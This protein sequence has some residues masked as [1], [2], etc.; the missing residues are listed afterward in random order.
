M[1]VYVRER[2]TERFADTSMP[3]DCRVCVRMCTCVCV[4]VCVYVRACACVCMC[5]YMFLY[6]RE[7]DRERLAARF[8]APRL[9]H[10]SCVYACV[11]E[12]VCVREKKSL[13]VYV[14][15]RVYV[16]VRAHLDVEIKRYSNERER[17]CAR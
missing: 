2:E 16:C 13:P 4:C 5:V 8:D 3:H 7:R 10:C 11:C 9:L 12:C 17:W 6:E 14:C 15:M 1:F